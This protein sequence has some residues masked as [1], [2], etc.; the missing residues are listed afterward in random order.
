MNL[1][2]TTG[3]NFMRI[4]RMG[5]GVIAVGVAIY[6]R[7]SLLGLAGAFLLLM[8]LFNLGCCGTGG[9]ALPNRN[10]H[11]TKQVVADEVEFEEVK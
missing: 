7:D 8:G 4:L 6:D 10:S 3:W 2:F 5:M 9:C 1:Q 11:T